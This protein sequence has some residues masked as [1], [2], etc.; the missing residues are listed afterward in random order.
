[1]SFISVLLFSV[2]SL[3]AVQ[4]P[5][6]INFYSLSLEKGHKVF[7]CEGLAHLPKSSKAG[8]AETSQFKV[9]SVCTYGYKGCEM[10]LG[11][12]ENL[13]ADQKKWDKPFRASMMLLS[14]MY[15]SRQR[16]EAL[17][18]A[19]K[20]DKGWIA[21]TKNGTTITVDNGLSKMLLERKG[22]VLQYFLDNF[23]EHT[24]IA[25]TKISLNGAMV[26]TRFNYKEMEGAIYPYKVNIKKSD[27]KGHV[28]SGELA[29]TKCSSHK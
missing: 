22:K 14:N 6:D 25:G 29:F 19:R 4:A 1:M 3:A 8:E 20:I 28:V 5:V 24:V 10:Y 7:I 18:Y 11:K 13:S 12:N 26:E 17:K 9:R 27:E 15:L 16:A 21:A 2:F 23:K